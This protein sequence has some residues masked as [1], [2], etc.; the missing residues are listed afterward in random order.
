MPG[1]ELHLAI[2]VDELEYYL[3]YLFVALPFKDGVKSA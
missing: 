1:G 3:Q 2:Q